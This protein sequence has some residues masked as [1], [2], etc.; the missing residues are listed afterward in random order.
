MDIRFRN[1]YR[2]AIYDYLKL[3]SGENILYKDICEELGVCYRTVQR[4]IHWLEKQHL[5]HRRGKR[6]FVDLF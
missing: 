4:H 3:N 6:I 5:I 2:K 1:V